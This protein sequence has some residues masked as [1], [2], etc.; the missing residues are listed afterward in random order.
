MELRACCSAYLR[1]YGEC[2]VHECG[3]RACNLSD[4]YVRAAFALSICDVVVAMCCRTQQRG[5]LNYFRN[6]HMVQDAFRYLPFANTDADVATGESF[7]VAQLMSAVHSVH[8]EV[9]Y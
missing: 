2:P 7:H 1:D 3:H 9:G 6:T 5:Y 8:C 4:G